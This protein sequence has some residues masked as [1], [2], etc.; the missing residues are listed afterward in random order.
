MTTKADLFNLQRFV[1]AQEG[2]YSDVL[3][4]LQ[5]GQKRTHWMWFIFPQLDGLGYSATSKHYA[6]KSISEAQHYL[7]HP[8]LG[9]RLIE[10]A[11]AV[12]AVKGRS[13]SAIFGSPDDMKLKSS[14][15]LFAAVAPP[16]SVFVRVLD[17]Y[18]SGKQDSKTLSL[19]EQHNT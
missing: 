3:A 5:S 13:A 2:V 19:M 9:P 17:V 1:S 8:V 4:E 14:M 16:Q 7:N 12:L 15:T 10:C 6:I 11:E 18:F